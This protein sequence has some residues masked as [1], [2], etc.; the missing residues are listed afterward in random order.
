MTKV[1]ARSYSGSVPLPFESCHQVLQDWVVYSDRI[2]AIVYS[3]AQA[4]EHKKAAKKTSTECCQCADGVDCAVNAAIK[5]IQSSDSVSSITCTGCNPTNH[6]L[7]DPPFP[8]QPQQRRWQAEEGRSQIGQDHHWWSSSPPCSRC[9][10]EKE[11]EGLSA[12]EHPSSV[13][14]PQR[15]KRVRKG[16]GKAA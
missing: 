11:R 1:I 2:W 15:S 3:V 16:K 7:I 14:Y 10:R 9:W 8:C 6:H 13:P 5:R 4:A 12:L